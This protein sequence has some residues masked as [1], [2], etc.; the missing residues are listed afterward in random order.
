MS[1]LCFGQE[2]TENAFQKIDSIELYLSKQ[3][4]SDSSSIATSHYF[5]GELF[6]KNT[7]YSDSAYFHYHKAEKISRNLRDN[8]GTAKILYGIAVIQQLE[9]DFIG[10][11]V[12]SIEAISLLESVSETDEVQQY[13]SFIY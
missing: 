1:F 9:K 10:S 12:T 11:E 8:L 3:K 7:P 5:I 6:R 4:L 13:R 2:Q